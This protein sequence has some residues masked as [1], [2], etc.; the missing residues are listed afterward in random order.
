MATSSDS[1]GVET[2]S[3]VPIVLQAAEDL[4]NTET[5]EQEESKPPLKIGFH[6]EPYPGTCLYD[7]PLLDIEEVMKSSHCVLPCL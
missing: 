3:V 7:A 4:A 2:D 1:Q 5:Q 6:L